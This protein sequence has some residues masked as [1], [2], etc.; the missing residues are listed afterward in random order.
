M[1]E[2]K[3]RSVTPEER[4]EI[5]ATL[6]R[7]LGP[8][9]IPKPK[10]VLRDDI[11]EPVRDADVHVSRADANTKGVAKVVEVQRPDYVSINVAAW[12]QQQAWKREDRR[13]RRELDPY[14]L[15]LYG[16]LDDD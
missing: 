6:D 2:E 1:P 7:I 14:R 5:E 8:M 12:E 4:A 10:V 11:P 9:P 13:R 16:P 15:G 3:K